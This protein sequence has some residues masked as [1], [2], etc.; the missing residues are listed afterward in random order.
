MKKFKVGQ[1]AWSCRQGEVVIV[2]IKEH[3][4]Y[5]IETEYA[6]YSLDGKV[7]KSDKHPTLFHSKQDMIEYFQNVKTKRTYTKWFNVY[8][9]GSLGGSFNSREGAKVID[10]DEIVDCVSLTYEVEE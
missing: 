9:N 10:C 1:K 8:A 5:P 3:E 4:P 7:L 6:T 2:G